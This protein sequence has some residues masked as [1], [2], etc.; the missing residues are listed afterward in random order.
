MAKKKT[1]A[2]IVMLRNNWPG[3]FR[4]AGLEFAPGV[5]QGLDESQFKAVAKDIGNALVRV[6]LDEIGR[7]RVIEDEPAADPKSAGPSGESS[8]D[9][10]EESGSKPAETKTDAK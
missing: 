2:A 1:I 8:A 9:E 7:P 5:P 6:E 3:N 4:R 10:G